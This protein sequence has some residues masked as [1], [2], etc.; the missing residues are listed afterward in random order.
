MFGVYARQTFYTSG[1]ACAP[2]T[3]MGPASASRRST[4]VARSNFTPGIL[5][6]TDGLPVHQVMRQIRP[7]IRQPPGVCTNVS[8]YQPVPF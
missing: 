6:L 2:R 7:Q 8:S 5:S 1:L 4:L 3:P